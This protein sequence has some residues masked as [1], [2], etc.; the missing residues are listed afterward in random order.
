MGCQLISKNNP[1]F[2][3]FYNLSG[4]SLLTIYNFEFIKPNKY[5][6]IE[7]YL[8]DDSIQKDS[9][10]FC[11]KYFSEFKNSLFFI[12][13]ESLKTSNKFNF[14][15][16]ISN[17]IQVL[18]LKND[19][20]KIKKILDELNISYFK[21]DK[22]FVYDKNIEKLNLKILESSPDVYFG[23]KKAN[24]FNYKFIH[25]RL[26]QY[27]ISKDDVLNAIKTNNN[28][29]LIGKYKRKLNDV[30]IIL[31]NKNYSSENYL[32]SK[33]YKS[34]VDVNMFLMQDITSDYLQ[35]A[36]K[37]GTYFAILKFKNPS[38]IRRVKLQ[39]R[40]LLSLFNLSI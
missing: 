11:K 1:H 34:L 7:F 2:I 31:K 22:Y 15:E 40:H 14:D 27:N 25:N 23:S 4:A 12:G 33:K 26:N 18:C 24:V 32:Y 28:G 37:N 13:S 20:F 36:Q 8:S 3:V 5:K 9:L 6:K 30:E 38:V 19:F 16:I 17:R 29:L 21:E 35:I 39:I 10:E